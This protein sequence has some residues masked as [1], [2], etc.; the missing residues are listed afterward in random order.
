[1]SEENIMI[2][3]PDISEIEGW[4]FEVGQRGA[5]S[6]L[7]GYN[8]KYKAKLS[9]VYAKKGKKKDDGRKNTNAVIEFTVSEKQDNGKHLVKYIPFDG[10]ND[11]G[12]P[13]TP[14]EV[15]K[16]LIRL[17]ATKDKVVA[18]AKAQAGKAID[19]A[20]LFKSYIGK[21]HVLEVVAEEGRGK[22]AGKFNSSVL[23][24]ATEQEYKEAAAVNR[25]KEPLSDDAQKAY[26]AQNGG[27]SEAP[28]AGPPA[29]KAAAKKA[30][31]P[32]EEPAAEPDAFE[33]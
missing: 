26:D 2:Q 6:A 13:I 14:L 28:T 8:G 20:A 16:F 23:G 30:E 1:M 15:F 18:L 7:L 5:I 29:K 9:K 3:M 10:V 32:T 12:N 21:E 24:V 11:E 27:A 31:E 4:D 33:I 19:P 17:G 25:L 22:H